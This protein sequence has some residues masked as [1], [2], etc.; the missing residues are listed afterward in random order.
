MSGLEFELCRRARDRR[1]PP[2][3]LLTAA[4]P[5][6]CR[7]QEKPLGQVLVPARLRATCELVAAEEERAELEQRFAA[8]AAAAAAG[9]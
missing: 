3:S 2:F 9:G 4:P 8:A 1:V 5:R 7:M 6:T